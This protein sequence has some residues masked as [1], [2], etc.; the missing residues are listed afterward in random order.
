MIR[1]QQD[2]RKSTRRWRKPAAVVT[3]LESYVGLQTA[4]TLRRH[5]IPVVALANRPNA[6]L[7]RTR[8][9]EAIF[10]AGSDGAGTVGVLQELAPLQLGLVQR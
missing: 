1:R 9:V 8:S 10:D 6:P 4:R 2:L 7:C 5:G 3:N